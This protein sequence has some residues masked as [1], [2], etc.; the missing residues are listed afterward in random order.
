MILDLD[1][2][3]ILDIFPDALKEGEIQ[4]KQVNGISSLNCA[5]VGDLSF[6]GQP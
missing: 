2:D 6:F 4:T 3:E 1:V 5:V